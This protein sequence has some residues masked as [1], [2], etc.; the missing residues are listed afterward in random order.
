MRRILAPLALI[1]ALPAAGQ[2]PSKPGEVKTFGDWTVGCDNARRCMMR[3][4]GPEFG[5]QQPTSLLITRDA[6]PAAG[7]R[8][9]MEAEDGRARGVA[10]DGKRLATGRIDYDGV[11]AAAIVAAMASGKAMQVLSAAG[12]P[13]ST[14]SLKGASAALRYIDAQQGRAGG[15]TAIV[16]KGAAPATS[17][18]PAPALPV[19]TAVTPA[20]TPAK[21]TAAQVAAMRK[22]AECDLEGFAGDSSPELH[23]LGGGATLILLP[24]SAGAYNITAA[25]F[26]LKGGQ[27]TPAD[28]DAPTSF[29][30]GTS[31]KGPAQLVNSGFAEGLVTSYAKGRGIGDCGISQDFAWDGTR[32]RLVEQAEMSECRGNTGLMTTWRATV[33]RK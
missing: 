3:S 28:T 23:A 26:M 7:V 21:P 20:G 18:P 15:V 25:A 27:V 17:V 12:R 14:V 29:G 6:G 33:R 13:Q 9:T 8:V 22:S 10:V 32:L 11:P 31:T 2:T 5:D 24:C 16:A 4:L 1:A 30:D 19:V